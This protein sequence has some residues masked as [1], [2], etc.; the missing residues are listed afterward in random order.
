MPNNFDIEQ[1]LLVSN[2][3]EMVAYEI[4]KER[5]KSNTWPIYL[6]TKFG[7]YL[8]KN[9]KVIF[10]I[11]GQDKKAQ[12][13]V[14]SAKIKNVIDKKITEF[15]LHKK[16]S[17]VICNLEFEDINLFEN[18]VNIKKHIDNLTFIKTENKRYFG[19]Y[20]QGGV[21]RIDK[22]SFNYILKHST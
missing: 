2:D 8:K 10:Y 20:L 18:D 22:Q 16:F 14:A 11:A 17:K 3:A 6:G 21:C 12:N 9:I 19:L 13:F 5:I 4:F 1:I 7:R 15:D